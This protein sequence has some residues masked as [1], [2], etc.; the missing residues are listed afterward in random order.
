M[1]RDFVK[2][3]GKPKEINSLEERKQH[4][5]AQFE[6]NNM[7]TFMKREKWGDM[8]EKLY[9]NNVYVQL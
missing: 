9:I 6:Q 2:T 1:F 4:L 8:K 7:I 3:S 5:N